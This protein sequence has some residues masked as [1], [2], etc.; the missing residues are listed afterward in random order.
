MH[1]CIRCADQG[2]RNT[3]LLFL[4]VPTVLLSACA[5]RFSVLDAK[6]YGEMA[7][8]MP[9]EL[10][11]HNLP[12]DPHA[13]QDAVHAGK[14]PYGTILFQQLSP[15]FMQ[16]ETA[17]YYLGETFAKT[18]QPRR[19]VV[20]HRQNGFTIVRHT[21]NA[22]DRPGRIDRFVYRH[23]KTGKTSKDLVSACPSPAEQSGNS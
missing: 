16:G 14:E 18:I 3:L 7:N 22:V 19:S 13:V 12:T 21:V 5:E 17:Q 4:L 8:Y 2:M 10:T 9:N 23:P 15:E 6:G 11:S 1:C 20:R